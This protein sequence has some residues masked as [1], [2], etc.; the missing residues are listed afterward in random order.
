MNWIA[1]TSRNKEQILAD[2]IAYLQ[3]TSTDISD[4]SLGNPL[5][6]SALIYAAIGEAINYNI[7]V[8]AQEGISSTSR[9]YRS[10]IAHARLANYRVKNSVAASMD[11]TFKIS[12]VASTS[13]VIPS[14]TKLT[15]SGLDFYTVAA[16][17]VLAGQTTVSVSAVESL[18][19][20]S[21]TAT[22][23]G[24][25]SQ[26]FF[27]SNSATDNTLTVLINSELWQRVENFA[28]SLP[29]DKHFIQTVGVEGRPVCLFGNGLNGLIPTNGTSI[30]FSYSRCSG[31]TANISAASISTITGTIT[32]PQNV[33]IS[34]FNIAAASGGVGIESAASIRRNT[35]NALLTVDRAVTAQ[36][37]EI[38]SEM[39]GGVSRA[40]VKSECGRAIE[41][42][43]VPENGGL[44]SSQLKLD[45]SNYLSTRKILGR[46]INVLSAGIV[47]VKLELNLRLGAT[48][49]P[50]TVIAA[51][52][53]NLSTK[54]SYLNQ[55]IN[56][57][58]YLSDITEII[59][60]TRGVNSSDIVLMN[61]TPYARP[62]NV[63]QNLD[64]SVSVGVDSTSVAVWQIVFL[65]NAKFQLFR[66]S[67]F[68][69]QF[70][71]GV[72]V[73]KYGVSLTINSDI[74]VGAKFEFTSYRN[75]GNLVLSEMSVPVIT[76]G[77]ITINLL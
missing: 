61:A 44:A 1:Y 13:I 63:Q 19:E 50:Q 3:S 12:E 69:G 16:C 10:A 53:S 30:G 73:Q 29:T 46:K 33:T 52:K 57:T 23:T 20:E 25:S 74:S 17:T 62:L 59:E 22:S 31:A 47:S 49:Q 54:F 43:I 11:V 64:W 67:T 35:P 55:R 14:Q 71:V 36:D 7:D 34:A 38:I 26:S 58:I 6:R 65:A 42:Y 28:F 2:V 76:E 68:L 18:T 15:A 41:I 56:S 40:G 27:I 48:S 75:V 72:L 8:A 32:L 5:I 24:E 37:F 51:V 9:T 70:D 77:D 4:V 66:N 45:V 60:T 21:V 39:V